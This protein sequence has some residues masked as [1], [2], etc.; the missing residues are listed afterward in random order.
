MGTVFSVLSQ[1][2]RAIVPQH[3]KPIEGVTTSK[4]SSAQSSGVW[5]SVP[6]AYI[7]RMSWLAKFTLF[8]LAGILRNR[9]LQTSRDIKQETGNK[10]NFI[11]PGILDQLEMIE[12]TRSAQGCY[13]RRYALTAKQKIILKALGITEVELDLEVSN[14]NTRVAH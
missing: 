3:L 12:C 7:Q 11:I 1:H 2:V 4:N 8:F 6:S 13:C 5:M 9:L 10:R 14:F